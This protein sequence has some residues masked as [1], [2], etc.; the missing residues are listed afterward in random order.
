MGLQ[1]R[2]KARQR[3]AFAMTE[4]MPGRTMPSGAHGLPP[5]SVEKG[6]SPYGRKPAFLH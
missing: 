1:E 4:R 3:R 5:E 6:G 2:T